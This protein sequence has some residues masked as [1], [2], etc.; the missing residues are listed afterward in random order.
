[1]KSVLIL[2]STYNGRLYLKEQLDSIYAQKGVDIYLLARDD[3]SKD[4]TVDM[5][6][7]YKQQFGKMTILNGANL[8]AGPSFLALINEAATNYSNYDYYAFSD[9]DDVWFED[10]L[11]KGVNSL[12]KSSNKYQLYFSGAINTD[13]RLHPY[14]STSKSQVV[15]SFGA[16][17]V[18]N[19]IL[20]CTMLFNKELLDEVNKI[21]TRTF[22]ISS[23]KVPIHDGWTSFVAYS[24][25]ADVVMNPVGMMYYRQHG[26]N[27]IGAGQ[28]RLKM[29]LKRVKR[30]TGKG[31]HQKANR[32]IIALQVLDNIPEDNR[33]LL[34]LVANYKK[35]IKSKVR[36]MLD[37]RMYEY[38]IIDNIGTFLLVLFNK[39]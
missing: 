15:N 1:M 14:R 33:K 8:G 26:G 30:Y 12:D 34:M 9:Q 19:H 23:G 2:L 20:G 17:L 6:Q 32:S 11:I 38:D 10:K 25:N 29:M 21:N 16:N 7:K 5:L 39:F 3:G 31:N 24:L 4:E 36:L 35:S 22:T 28:G 13:A 37:E 18:A 27:E